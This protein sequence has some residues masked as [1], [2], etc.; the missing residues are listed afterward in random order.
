MV[1]LQ[2]P[3]EDQER[4][5]RCSQSVSCFRQLIRLP[6]SWRSLM[7]FLMGLFGQMSGNVSCFYPHLVSTRRIP[8]TT[9]RVSDTST[10]IYTNPLVT[11]RT[12]NSSST[13][14]IRSSRRS[15][16]GLQ[17]LSQVCHSY[18]RSDSPS[19]D[20]PAFRQA[21]TAKGP[22]HWHGGVRRYAGLQCWILWKM[23]H[24]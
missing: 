13:S 17:Q 5:V 15:L 4:S 21:A 14:P 8:I 16:P 3:V 20:A 2:R 19:S 22:G 12:C 23:G 11:L 18:P 10:S 9:S 7:V 1:G 24:L 6:Y